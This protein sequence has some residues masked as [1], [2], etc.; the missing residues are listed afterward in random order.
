MLNGLTVWLG[1]DGFYGFDGEK[2]R[3]VSDG[4][5]DD[6]IKRINSTWRLRAVAAVESRMGEYRCWIP[7]DGAQVNNL[8]VV[9]NGMRW[10]ERTDVKAGAVCVTRDDRQLMLALGTVAVTDPTADLGSVWVLDHEAV[11]VRTPAPRDSIIETTW[12]R[13]TVSRRQGSPTDLD[14]WLRESGRAE[15]TVEVMRDWRKYPVIGGSGEPPPLYP[16]QDR[17]PFWGTAVYNEDYKNQMTSEVIPRHFVR[18]RPYW[19]NVA[20]SV[21]SCETFRV[22]LKY[23]GDLE[24]IGMAYVAKDRHSGGARVPEGG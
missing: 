5:R 4:I 11:S 1:R 6:I 12:L 2:V 14:I 22:R 23:A 10:S 17:P 7:V 16:D 21:P 24:F 15:L 3:P 9:F 18:R 13:S 19:V 20:L 8:C